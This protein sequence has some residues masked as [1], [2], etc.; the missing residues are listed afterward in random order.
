M[1]LLVLILLILL[2]GGVG[3]W[4]PYSSGWGFAPSGILSLIL[5]VL[6]IRL[7]VG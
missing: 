1:N 4:W 3:P 2:I 7:L 6:L 5:L